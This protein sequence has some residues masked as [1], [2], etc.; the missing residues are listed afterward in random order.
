VAKLLDPPDISWVRADKHL[1]S[2]VDRLAAVSAYRGKRAR[3]TRQFVKWSPA[4][5][6]A[7]GL[8]RPTA[9]GV[10][11]RPLA[12]RTSAC[13]K[14]IQLPSNNKRTEVTNPRRFLSLPSAFAGYCTRHT[15]QFEKVRCRSLSAAAPLGFAHHR[16]GK[17]SPS[18]HALAAPPRSWA[19]FTV[20]GAVTLPGQLR[21][22]AH[23]FSSRCRR[24]A[25]PCG[26]SA[27]SRRQSFGRRSRWFLR[28]GFARQGIAAPI[29]WPTEGA[30]RP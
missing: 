1:P 16:R 26:K 24:H 7:R 30:A 21:P 20:G 6:P 4:S 22:G 28:P 2:R 17:V 19:G 5:Q 18:V 14:R 9:S 3:D 23:P 12:R 15:R 25:P 10:S 11:S 27:A 8:T 29:P 13:P